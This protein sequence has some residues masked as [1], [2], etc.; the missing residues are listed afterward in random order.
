MKANVFI[1][2]VGFVTVCL[3]GCSPSRLEQ[4]LAYSGENRAEL[5][6]VLEHY[7]KDKQDSLKLR[8]AEFLIENMPGHYGMYGEAMDKY[9]Q[10]IDSAAANYNYIMRRAL[11]CTAYKIPSI[12]AT[13]EAIEDIHIITADY[14]IRNIDRS[15]EIWE[16]YPWC[17]DVSFEDFCNYILPHRVLNE[18]LDDWKQEPILTDEMVDFYTHYNTAYDLKT[19]YD[20][21]FRRYYSRNPL[22]YTGI[23]LPDGSPLP[24]DCIETAIAE[25]ASYRS[26]GMPAAIDFFVQ[27]YL[28]DGRHYMPVVLDSKY[29]HIPQRSS[30]VQRSTKFL[31]CTY[32][33]N[34]TPKEHCLD[35]PYLNNSHW[36]DVTDMYMA[37]EDISVFVPIKYLR[38]TKTAYVASFNSRRWEPNWWSDIKGCKAKFTNLVKHNMYLPV[39]YIQ[40]EQIP[41]D[42]PFYISSNRKVVFKPNKDSLISMSLTRKCLNDFMRKSYWQQGIKDSYIEAADNPEFKDANVVGQIPYNPYMTPYIINV[43]TTTPYRYWRYVTHHINGYV[44]ELDICKPTGDTIPPSEY[45]HPNE[46]PEVSRMYDDDVLTFYYFHKGNCEFDFHKPVQLSS[47][48]FS[49]RMDGNNV[50]PGLQYELYYWDMKGWQLLEKATATDNVLHFDKVPSNAV[51]WLRCISEGKEERIFT[52]DKNGIRFW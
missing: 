12:M 39:I 23:L 27:A 31:R 41:I 4:A 43:N 3:L 21:I 30:E 52:F 7:S 22:S 48:K 20:D 45:A 50:R 15:F 28:G 38:H 40:G 47:F 8:A 2:F 26:I 51:Y 46:R 34:P 36:L 25:V 10:F 19:L 42:Y 17:A 1:V 49:P 44:G 35:V 32:T 5:E 33:L 6:S 13:L 37:N 24:K 9:K 29:N 11:Y 16:Q 14:M 18:P